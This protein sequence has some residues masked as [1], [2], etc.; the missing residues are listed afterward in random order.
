MKYVAEKLKIVSKLLRVFK[1]SCKKKFFGTDVKIFIRKNRTHILKV[2]YYNK[3]SREKNQI[4][5]ESSYF[6][7]HIISLCRK[8][9][10][11]T[12]AYVDKSLNRLGNNVR[13]NKAL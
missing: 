11:T 3:L 8:I 4:V 5:M 6:L 9:S 7:Y 1:R 13:N 2:L 12:R 10:Q